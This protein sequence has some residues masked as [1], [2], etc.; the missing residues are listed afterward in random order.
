MHLRLIH[1]DFLFWR[2]E[3]SRIALSIAG[4]PFEDVCPDRTAF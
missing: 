4:I 3:E 1:F 2:A